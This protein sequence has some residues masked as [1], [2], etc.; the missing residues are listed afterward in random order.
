[1]ATKF[2]SSVSV[3][4]HTTQQFLMLVSSAF[5]TLG[6]SNQGIDEKFIRAYTGIN[7][8]SWG[9]EVTVTV[10]GSE[11][12]VVS[13]CTSWQLTDWGRNKKNVNR[14]LEAIEVARTE[15]TPQQLQ[16]QYNEWR[17][18]VEQE[19]AELRER[20]EQ[21]KL[22]AND[23]LALGV[24]GYYVTYTLIGINV[25]VFIVMVFGGVNIFNPTA[26]DILTWGGNM[27]AYTASGEW[28]RLISCVFVHIG[29]IHLFFNMYALYSIGIYLEP[30]IGRWNY[31]AAYLATGVLASVTSLWWSADRV[32]AGASGAIF[33]MYGF[34]LALLTTNYLNK[35][36]R[37]AV[38][39]SILVFVAFNLIYGMRAGVD[40][41]AHVGGLVSGFVLGYIFYM[42]QK[43]YNPRM[44][45]IAI[46][47]AITIVASLLVLKDKN[48]D[49]VKFAKVWDRFA[50]LEQKGL[51]P[52]QERDKLSSTE[53]IQKAENISM[54]ACWK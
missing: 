9:E 8:A 13:K 28:W 51:Q 46:A 39:S 36:A 18:G 22:T 50:V 34:F 40:N 6:W 19:E 33:G 54:P 5:T 32:S 43:K 37:K 24:G 20:L 16:Y 2:Q 10:N 52:L 38:L 4:E 42:L 15:H 29:I 44:V 17:A 25:L 41:A 14:V 48:D 27:R 21:D 31:L 30:I 23:K 3:G 26:G 12:D 35:E 47:A 7:A 45:F 1:M 53:F 11:A 49:S